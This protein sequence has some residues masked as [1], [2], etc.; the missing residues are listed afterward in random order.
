MLDMAL[1]TTVGAVIF[2]S[3]KA[4]TNENCLSFCILD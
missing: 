1:S 3:R 4:A 2:L